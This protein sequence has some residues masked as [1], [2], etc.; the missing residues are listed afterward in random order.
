[1]PSNQKALSRGG[2]ILARRGHGGWM[3]IIYTGVADPLTPVCQL[4]NE[5]VDAMTSK[6][7][8]QIVDENFLTVRAKLLEVAATFDRIDRSVAEGDVLSKSAEA[9]RQKLA[10][11]VKILLS[12]GPDRAERLQ[13]LFSRPYEASWRETMQV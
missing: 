9:Q 4:D 7:A 12:D 8:E 13:H 10:S 6:T 5:C 11:A 3:S 2:P 1:M